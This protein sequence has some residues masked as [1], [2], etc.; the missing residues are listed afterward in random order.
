MIKYTMCCWLGG[1]CWGQ[2]GQPRPVTGSTNVKYPIGI[3]RCWLGSA[4]CVLRPTEACCPC[5]VL[6][7]FGD[8]MDTVS[9]HVGGEWTLDAVRI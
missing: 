3:V 9:Q 5:S 4:G 8:P 2:V 1:G 6:C 7:G